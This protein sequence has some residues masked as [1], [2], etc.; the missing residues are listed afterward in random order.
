MKKLAIGKKLYLSF[1]SVLCLLIITGGVSIYELTDI[2]GSFVELIDVYGEMNEEATEVEVSLLTA[3][4]HEKDFIARAD[5][6]YIERMDST[7]K[8]L[9][10]HAKSISQKAETINFGIA[11]SESKSILNSTGSY[12]T[13][14]N[15]VA[16]SIHDQG[17]KDTGIRGNLRKHA[18]DMETGI[19]KSGSDQLMVQ[20][21]LLRRHEKDFIM[22]HDN[23]YVTKA[24]KVLK[25]IEALL[26]Q[27]QIEQGLGNA[28]KTSARSYVNTFEKLAENIA[29]IEEQY[30]VM[31]KA[32]HDIEANVKKLNKEVKEIVSRNKS[33][34]MGQKEN[35]ILLL[36]I[37][38]GLTL[39]IGIFL[40]I[41]SVRAITKPINRI[42]RNLG[43]GAAQIESASGQ[44]SSS[45]QS[46]AEGSSE[47]AASIE[48]TSSAL[49]EMASMT[50]QNSDNAD[51]AN[52][53]MGEANQVVGE[54]NDSMTDLT[55]S[56]EEISKASEETSKIVKTID[57]IAF[58]TNLL[59]LNAA[60]EAARA[61]E[62][63]AGFAV[64]AD[65][66][67][68]LALRAADAAKNT[69]NLIEGTVTK[70][71]NGYELVTKTN[72]AFSGVEEKSVKVGELV[73]E[74]TAASKEQS[75]GIEQ[76]NKTVN[77]MD[78]VVQQ[79]AANAEESAS[80][81]EELN[82][83]CTESFNMVEE[84]KQL[85]NGASKQEGKT[86]SL[87]VHKDKNDTYLSSGTL[88]KAARIK[89]VPNNKT[90]GMS[91]EKLIP[92][93]EK[94]FDEF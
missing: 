49:E 54:A 56:M 94:D 33:A 3:R 21:L 60:V 50:R 53:L 77:Q 55:S 61:G 28:I 83:Q 40:S 64:V 23:K 38:G 20:Y 68:N 24:Q 32:A 12:E 25:S 8:E 47:Q 42:I 89:N 76:I 4:R 43:E 10:S 16:N 2:T 74:I 7:L 62:A 67:R 75:E 86:G 72:E 84:L 30:P 1:A 5:K 69:S 41:F 14:F 37:I 59:A 71:N 78:H 92:L 65:E 45:S 6:K 35:T 36:F 88:K 90:T 48:E 51:Q 27:G 44:V 79:N 66:V 70:I 58:Q 29:A 91:P 17:D 11:V 19:K 80:A 13:A 93:D 52:I 22:R 31:R 15:N 46:L 39:V 82:A 85:V 9:R 87:E 34:A 73:A 57:D 63:G 18:H 26:S 81:S